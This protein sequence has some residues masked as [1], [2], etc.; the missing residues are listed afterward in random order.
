MPDLSLK[1]AKEVVAR[2]RTESGFPTNANNVN[3]DDVLVMQLMGELKTDEQPS[4]SQ[5]PE[6]GG[7]KY[8]NQKIYRK[9][10]KYRKSRKH[11]KSKRH[12]KR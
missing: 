6:R 2:R 4:N 10:K 1:E 5:P 3:D 9:S 12:S 7:R 8:R 11:R